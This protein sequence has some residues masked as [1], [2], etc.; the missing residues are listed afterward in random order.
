MVLY[1]LPDR[2]IPQTLENTFG[3]TIRSRDICHSKLAT[4]RHFQDQGEEEAANMRTLNDD[5]PP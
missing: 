2:N 3:R 1:C 5:N 4:T